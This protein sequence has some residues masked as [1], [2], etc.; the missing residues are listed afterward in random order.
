M[1]EFSKS[2]KN[3]KLIK[4][5]K[6]GKMV[7]LLDPGTE[8][9]TC[10]MAGRGMNGLKGTI[11]CYNPNNQR[12]T[13]ELEKGDMMSLRIRNVRAAGVRAAVVAEKEVT[14]KASNAHAD[15]E[16][17]PSPSAVEDEVGKDT[18]STSTGT[19]MPRSRVQEEET[20]FVNTNMNTGGNRNESQGVQQK[21]VFADIISPSSVFFAMLAVIFYL[22]GNQ[23]SSPPSGSENSMTFSI[24]FKSV[25]SPVM[26]TVAV[27]S[28]LTWEWGTKPGRRARGPFLLSNVYLRLNYCG[29]F[30][31]MG[32]GALILW[33]LGQ[34]VYAIVSL[35]VVAF[36][37][38]QFGTMNGRRSFS[39]GNVKQRL[40]HLNIWE[41]LMLANV[42]QSG[43]RVV[44]DVARKLR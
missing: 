8:A 12:Y 40:G 42:L 6:F 34:S 43:L 29:I 35:L 30:E 21:S 10:L 11:V 37:G 16:A 23:N 24:P 1:Y 2:F 3:L 36:F 38:W 19:S 28:Y 27:F 9:E 17:S 20:G 4:S 25:S 13:L 15:G 39:W 32:L 33:T 26:I 7:E 44:N 18:N 41:V 22:N 5:K 14:K 31:I